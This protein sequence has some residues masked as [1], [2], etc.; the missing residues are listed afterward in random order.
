MGDSKMGRPTD[1]PKDT[2]LKFRIDKETREML[3]ICSERL[4]ISQSEIIRSS[5]RK[6]YKALPKK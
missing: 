3:K 5:I 1:S 2:T 6:A 4:G